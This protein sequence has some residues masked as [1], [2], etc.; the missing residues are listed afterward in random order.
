M[1][2]YKKRLTEKTKAG[3][4]MSRMAHME[5]ALQQNLNVS[6]GDVIMYVN[7]GL[8]ASHGDVQKKGDGVQ[9]NCYMLDKDIL[10]N[11]PNLT[12]DYNV[13]RA[14]TTFNK[15]IEP[16]LV[17]FKTEVREALIVNNPEDRGIFT[18]AQCEL[19]NGE[20]FEESD[21]DK[22]EDVLAITDA[23]MSYWEKRGLK[24][25]YMYDLA[26]EGWEEKLGV[27]ETV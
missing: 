15:R 24:P 13:P 19:I 26:E 8:K 25:D 4:S 23:E 21:Q 22:L 7:N 11:D 1:E 6:L 10:D 2:D 12:G 18:T 3:N 5:L 20:P 14:I 17:C 9:I 16:L 27:L